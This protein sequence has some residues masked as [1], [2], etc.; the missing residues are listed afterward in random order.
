MDTREIFLDDEWRQISDGIHHI[1]L[2]RHPAV[3]GGEV[4]F[5]LSQGKPTSEA[6]HTLVGSVI[7]SSSLTV[8]CRAPGGSSRVVVSGWA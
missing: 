5:N 3:T 2:E 7:I 6:G 4:L 1:Y 8:W